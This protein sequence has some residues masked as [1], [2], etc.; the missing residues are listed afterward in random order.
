[1]LLKIDRFLESVL[2]WG[3]FLLPLFTKDVY[4]IF[5]NG[6]VLALEDYDRYSDEDI[7]TLVEEGCILSLDVCV[8][9]LGMR[10]FPTQ[11]SEMSTKDMA[12]Y[13]GAYKVITGQEID[14][15]GSEETD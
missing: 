1:M 9:W 5:D 10:F 14:I 8:R 4:I 2:Y 12:L 11:V 6:T 7:L 13:A 15:Y 3:S